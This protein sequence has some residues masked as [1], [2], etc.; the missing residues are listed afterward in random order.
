[1]TDF[2][3]LFLE[4]WEFDFSVGEFANLRLRSSRFEEAAT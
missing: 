2:V 3:A 4:F 1:M